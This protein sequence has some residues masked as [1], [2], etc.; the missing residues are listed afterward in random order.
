MLNGEQFADLDLDISKRVLLNVF[1]RNCRLTMRRRS[2]IKNCIFDHCTFGLTPYC[3]VISTSLIW[4][5]TVE[6]FSRRMNDAYDRDGVD[7][8]VPRE[9]DNMAIATTH[10]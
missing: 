7:I 10:M 1:F 8:V 4:Q 3:E 9:D 6:P 5:R 2:L